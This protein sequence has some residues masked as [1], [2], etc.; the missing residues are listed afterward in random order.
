VHP[1]ALPVHRQHHGVVARPELDVADALAHQRTGLANHSL[2]EP[3]LLAVDV[4]LVDLVAGVG[5]QTGD[6]A[7][8]GDGA[9]VAS[10]PQH[11]VGLERV[12]AGVHDVNL[13]S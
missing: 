4:E 6:F 7:N 11:V 9:G 1:H 5:R 10:V 3:P 12:V 2:D 8:H 13:F